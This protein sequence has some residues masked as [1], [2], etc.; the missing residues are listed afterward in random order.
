MIKKLGLLLCLGFAAQAPITASPS[1]HAAE[2]AK[3]GAGVACV[4]GTVYLI[5]SYPE[6]FGK[7]FG[8]LIR[9]LADSH[10]CYHCECWNHH[11]C[12][13]APRVTVTYTTHY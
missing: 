1:R 4:A 13:H 5:A 6:A 8:A 12:Y 10:Y 7:F 11:H 3:I 2:I 9:V